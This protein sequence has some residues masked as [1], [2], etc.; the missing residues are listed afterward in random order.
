MG[1]KSLRYQGIGLGL[2][3]LLAAILTFIFAFLVQIDDK[4][5]EFPIYVGKS[6]WVDCENFRHEEIDGYVDNVT[7]HDIRMY[8]RDTV[9]NSKT[10]SYTKMKWDVINLSIFTTLYFAISAAAHLLYTSPMYWKKYKSEM[11]EGRTLSVRWIEYAISAA[12]AF[13]PIAYFVGFQDAWVIGLSCS[14]ISATNMAA[15]GYY[16]GQRLREDFLRHML[17]PTI[18]Y[19]A[20]LVFLIFAFISWN[21]DNLND[22]PG[23]VYAILIG[24]AVLYNLFPVI[25][26]VEYLMRT[27]DGYLDGHRVYYIETAYNFASAVSKLFLGGVLAFNVFFV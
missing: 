3:H 18:H 25:F 1:L 14:I 13:V 24:E 16:S 19:M 7:A 15:Y 21:M 20:L 8:C 4:G 6:T 10:M 11:E 9:K 27:E 17:F 12:I 5:T 26:F 2:A 23:F 22:I